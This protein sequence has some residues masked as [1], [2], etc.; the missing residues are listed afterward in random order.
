MKCLSDR[1]WFQQ[2]RWRILVIVVLLAACQPAEQQTFVESVPSVTVTA[3][4]VVTASPS[5]TP[6]KFIPTPTIE[7]PPFDGNQL[8]LLKPREWLTSDFTD[9]DFQ[10]L[11]L[12][13]SDRPGHATFSNFSLSTLWAEGSETHVYAFSPDGQRSGTLLPPEFASNIYLPS[14]PAQKP[15]LVEYGVEFNHPDIQGI[16]LPAECYQPGQGEDQLIACGNFEFSPDG[17]YLGYFYGY[18]ECWRGIII[19]DT[20]TGKQVYHS[21]SK[22][23]H[24]FLLLNNGK[25]L[26]A[27]GHCEGGGVVSH[28]FNTGEV[29]PLGGEGGQ[30]WNLDHSAFAV[31]T[32]SYAGI[33]SSIW[34]FNLETEN[35]FLKSPKERQIDDHPVWTPDKAYLLYQHRTFARAT[36]NYT[37]SGFDQ[38]RQIILVNAQSGTQK[39]LLSDPAYDFHIGTCSS[40]AQWY[41]D[42]IQIHRVAFTPE[43]VTGGESMYT[44]QTFSC[45]MYADNC[46]SPVEQYGLN[47]KTGELKP[48]NELVASGLVPDLNSSETPPGPDSSQQPIFERPDQYTLYAG[49]RENTFWV[50]WR[51]AGEGTGKILSGPDLAT[52]P[53][54]EDPSGAYAYYVGIDSKSLWM[55][56]EEGI[57]L[58]WVMN[59]QN[60]FYLG[61]K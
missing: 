53:I 51:Y 8:P 31:E 41:G 18:P 58:P 3:S 21:T 15:M 45:R 19:Q 50:D 1:S 52:E 35:L 39:P 49:P 40:C 23:G 30:I 48:W 12:F 34:G 36:D 24:S 6:T 37:P 22:D 16:E 4:P 38:S 7:T 11:I 46:A 44:S 9:E 43:P 13:I 29:K 59:G 60:Y 61:N 25:A 56:P 57:P 26:I 14:D 33:D 28:D 10:D 54:Y 47:W 5:T 42:W 32:H 2:K 20:Q 17:K 55:V 27:T